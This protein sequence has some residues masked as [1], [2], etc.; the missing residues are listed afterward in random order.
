MP[1]EDVAD[2]L[3]AD[4]RGATLAVALPEQL[5]AEAL[6]R[7]FGAH[8]L[9]VVGWYSALPAVIEKLRRCRPGIVIVDPAIGRQD[10]PGVV[11]DALRHASATTRI[12]VL[13]DGSTATSRTRSSTRA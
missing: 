11:L 7:S 6:A 10:E 12:V 5:I 1:G 2:D 8:G 4:A 3:G 9:H 13:A